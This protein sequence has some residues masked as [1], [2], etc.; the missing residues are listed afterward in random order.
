MGNANDTSRFSKHKINSHNDGK[1][2]SSKKVKG[3]QTP[4]SMEAHDSKAHYSSTN[5]LHHQCT[6]SPEVRES[7]QERSCPP[8][9]DLSDN[10][11]SLAMGAQ[12]CYSIGQ[13]DYATAI[14][15]GAASLGIEL[16]EHLQQSLC[17][18]YG[19]Y[20]SWSAARGI[21][22]GQDAQALGCDFLSGFGVVP[23]RQAGRYE[24]EARYFGGDLAGIGAQFDC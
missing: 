5:T 15:D 24:Q 9:R 22:I 8:A 6:S 16:P 21:T 12:S 10:S 18:R 7:L 1:R 20:A 2:L 19:T 13:I 23:Y 3:Y 4:N 14:T 11:P 17:D